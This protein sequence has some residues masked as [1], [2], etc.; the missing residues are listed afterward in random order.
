[1]P[2]MTSVTPQSVAAST[3]VFMP[4][5]MDSQPSRPKRLAV[6]YLL[7]RNDSKWSDQQRRSSIRSF[8]SWVNSICSDVSICSRIQFTCSWSQ[9][10]MYSTPIDDA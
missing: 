5:I 3:M 1:M 7:A 9:M 8:S 6:G 4:P 10:C 2:M